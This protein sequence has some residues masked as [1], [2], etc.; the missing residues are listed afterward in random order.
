MPVVSESWLLFTIGLNGDG[1][2]N[3]NVNHISMYVEVRN[4]P[5]LDTDDDICFGSQVYPSYK[6]LP[7]PIFPRRAS[8]ILTGITRRGD[9]GMNRGG[10]APVKVSRSPE[11]EPA[12]NQ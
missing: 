6:L 5:Q 10:G 1:N 11:R 2:I 9:S 12:L 3:K 8:Q 4:E 7:S